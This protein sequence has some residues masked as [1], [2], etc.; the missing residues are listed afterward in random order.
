[1]ESVRT[2]EGKR[3]Y[4]VE[5]TGAE[6]NAVLQVED[7]HGKKRAHNEEPGVKGGGPERD[8][9]VSKILSARWSRR[10]WLCSSAASG[11]ELLK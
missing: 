3:K 8:K 2:A 1:M 5:T 9:K 7:R 10:R 11:Q 4:R 6:S